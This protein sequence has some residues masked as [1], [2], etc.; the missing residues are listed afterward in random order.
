MIEKYLIRTRDCYKAVMI[1][2]NTCANPVEIMNDSEGNN[3]L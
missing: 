1:I 2:K 3:I